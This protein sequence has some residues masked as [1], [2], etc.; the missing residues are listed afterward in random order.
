MTNDAGPSVEIH[1][2]ISPTEHFYTM[3]HYLAAS[4]RNFGGGA[5]SARLVVTVGDD[6]EPRDLYAELPWS[7]KYPIEWRWMDRERF[8]AYSYYGTA[9][10]RLCYR[11]DADVVIMLDADVLVTA[12]LDDLIDAVYSKGVFAGLITHVS[13]FVCER[14]KRSNAE[15]WNDVFRHAALPLPNLH[16]EH[17]GWGVME[18]DPEYRYGPAYFNFGVVAGPRALFEKMGPSVY[19][20]M[21]HVVRAVGPTFFRCQLALTLGLYRANAE[22]M[23]LPMRY[24]FPN[25]SGFAE[26]FSHELADV[27]VIHYLGTEHM[28]KRADFAT[29]DAVGAFIARCP[30]SDVHGVFKS[31]LAELHPLVVAEVG[32]QG[33]APTTDLTDPLVVLG[34]HRSG[35]SALTRVL[36]LCGVALG[37]NL[38]RPQPDNPAGFW[39]N[40]QIV[41][42]NDRLLSALGLSWDSTA[43]LPEHWKRSHE[44]L[45]IIDGICDLLRREFAGCDRWAI[46]DPRLC[47][48]L[49]IWKC[50]FNKLG[51]RPRYVHILRA[52]HEVCRSL[53]ARNGLSDGLCG[54]LWLRY[55]SDVQNATC[56]E[57]VV[58]VTYDGLLR[59]WRHLVA[60]VGESLS[61]AMD[62]G[63]AAGA[64]DAFVRPS[65]RHH[66]DSDES[67]PE[68]LVWQLCRRL[69]GSLVSAHEK[70][71][72]AEAARDAAEFLDGDVDQRERNNEY[73]AVEEL[74][75]RGDVA[76][77][78][79]ALER[80]IRD[81]PTHALAR[82]DAG[83]LLAAHG[84]VAHA[85]MW[86]QQAHALAPNSYLILNNLVQLLVSQKEFASAS[87]LAKTFLLRIP[88]HDDALRLAHSLMGD[89]GSIE[90][91][92]GRRVQ[93][94]G[95][96]AVAAS[97]VIPVFDQ[98]SFTRN[99]LE[100]L[101][102]VTGGVAGWEVI[103]VDDGSTDGT[104]DYLQEAARGY[105]NLRV[106]RN[107][108][109]LGFS[110]A[111]NAGAS[112]AR[113][114]HIVFLNNDT[115]PKAGWLQALV[116]TADDPKVG[117]VGAKLV[118]PVDADSGAEYVQHAG[119]AFGADRNS[120]HLYKFCLEQ[121]PFVN[122]AR[123]LQAVTGAAMLVRADLFHAAGGFDT[124]YRNG[125]E[126]LDLCFKI[127]AAGYT[128]RYCPD[129]VITHFES[130][131][132]R[133][134]GQ[135]GHN[136][137]DDNYQRF[138]RR[139][140][141]H[142]HAD[143]S[144]I[145][146]QDRLNMP[147]GGM[148]RIAL[149][150]PLPPQKSGV[151]YYTR[152]LLP[153]LAKHACV[154]LFADGFAPDD[155]E[156]LRSYRVHDLKHL[157]YVDWMYQYDQII[158]HLGNN[159]FHT[160]IYEM[161]KRKP[162]VVVI[163]E[164]DTR[165][166]TDTVAT[167]KELFEWVVPNAK[168]IIV[169][170]EHSQR[171][172]ASEFSPYPIEVIPL[173][174]HDHTGNIRGRDR[175]QE[176]IALG[177]EADA[178]LV[179]SLGL[180]QYHKRNHITLEAFAE[181]AAQHPK[182]QLVLGGEALDK[183]Y[184]AHLDGAIAKHGL[185]DRVRITGWLSD[186]DF[187]RYLA[188]CD[189]SVNLRYPAR[190][191]ES[192]GLYWGLGSGKPVLVSNYAQF[193]D[194]PDDCVVKI[195]FA[196]EVE[197]IVAALERFHA[198]PR[199]AQEL[200]ERAVAFVQGRNVAARIGELYF[201]FAMR[202]A[203]RRHGRRIAADPA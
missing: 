196:D 53:S 27:R 90:S 203:E 146:R 43:P 68:T 150:S 147:A 123:E 195:D 100:A 171:L 163:H 106:V 126:D 29:V 136:S 70:R 54:Q 9:I 26:R 51:V 30:D 115:L 186:D 116:A 65:M 95:E 169:H 3:V 83:V 130:V 63:D 158:Y 21:A 189:V 85:T 187:W 1:V 103:V 118:F 162:G 105:P 58:T 148:A 141:E 199:A 192:G 153:Q 8:R 202:V 66:H 69:F 108:R 117:I 183:R 124:D 120:M 55:V 16:Y 197:Q 2:P 144:L 172:L 14:D 87:Q 201:D 12:P 46:K 93:L 159:K 101:F 151:C 73:G 184:L 125:A 180:V 102:Q 170:N 48:L 127:R 80:I 129:S 34:M 4:L 79:S 92:A 62:L 32:L 98:V 81:D 10:E 139:W 72:A 109:N 135:Q 37:K 45:Q 75:H 41:D 57:T 96:T 52:P 152:E 49:P 161:A 149:V 47:R 142:I 76:A 19:Q 168:G 176:K 165:G 22:I 122:R 160:G 61:I 128:V 94:L 110:G 7:R 38:M 99:C 82:N 190:G 40:Q 132:V 191:E 97:V 64:V 11:Y 104:W 28:E 77:A 112:Q 134:A 31:K 89:A 74:I 155:D 17:T 18:T 60:K 138:L 50:V 137:A 88:G 157:T 35:T 181:F 200:G 140:G 177:Y 39:E 13:P 20:D 113:G 166:C 131:T 114:K 121:Q 119:I 107:D 42:F 154:D 56:G 156:L 71:I 198:D 133:A 173:I 179:V 15:C 6:C 178:Y 175:A 145:Y 36:N 194:L 91:R 143:E 185:Q 23:A 33:G 67:A 193:G 59:N 25:R 44:V 84:D 5:A 24:N 111:C 167:N 188:A 86:L 78:V 164:Y 182:A 174:L